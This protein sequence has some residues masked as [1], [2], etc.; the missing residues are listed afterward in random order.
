LF[1]LLNSN[2]VQRQVAVKTFTQATLSTIGNRLRDI[3]LPIANTSEERE[4]IGRH[5]QDIIEQKTRLR[6]QT[7]RLIQTSL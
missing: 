2:I 4:R 1:Y 3:I 5:V 6:E 7:L